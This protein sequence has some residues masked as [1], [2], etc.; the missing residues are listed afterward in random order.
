MFAA[1][2]VDDRYFCQSRELR[3]SSTENL[4]IDIFADE[5]QL[6]VEYFGI[7]LVLLLKL[8]FGESF[9]ALSP[10]LHIAFIESYFSGRTIVRWL[11]W[12]WLSRTTSKELAKISNLHDGK[13]DV[14][15]VVDF[16]DI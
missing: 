13:E 8:L 2:D 3:H 11:V 4:N 1:A 5:L 6:R 14:G 12:W 15:F 16:G 7:L 9:I 10:F